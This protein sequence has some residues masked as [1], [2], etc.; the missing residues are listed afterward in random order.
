MP[1]RA[2]TAKSDASSSTAAIRGRATAAT[3]VPKIPAVDEIHKARKFALR[4]TSGLRF[5]G[6]DMCTD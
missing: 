6:L 4:T 5:V 2:A 3:D 1:E